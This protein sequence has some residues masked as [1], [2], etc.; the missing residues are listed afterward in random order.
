MLLLMVVVR[1]ASFVATSTFDA[2]DIMCSHMPRPGIFYV[3]CGLPSLCGGSPNSA[4]LQPLQLSLTQG[5]VRTVRML[6]VEQQYHDAYR[7]L[8]L[9]VVRLVLIVSLYQPGMYAAA[10]VPLNQ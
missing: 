5:T 6:P 3:I 2:R 1:C 9:L 8:Y 4:L 10:V 7:Y